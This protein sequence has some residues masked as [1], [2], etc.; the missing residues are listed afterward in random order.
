MFNEAKQNSRVSDL[1]D[2][3]ESDKA[4]GKMRQLLL[5]MK[6]RC[7]SAALNGL[8]KEFPSIPLVE[9]VEAYETYAQNIRRVFPNSQD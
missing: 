9:R 6:P 5:S 8:Q 3:P 4:P 7:A 1:D 2:F